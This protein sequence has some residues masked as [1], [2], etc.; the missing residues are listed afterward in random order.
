MDPEPEWSH[1]EVQDDHSHPSYRDDA[2]PYSEV[3][4]FHCPSDLLHWNITCRCK[5]STDTDGG[6]SDVLLSSAQVE[7]G[8]NLDLTVPLK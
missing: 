1:E 3:A 5:P 6:H 4:T 8:N 2:T 7:A